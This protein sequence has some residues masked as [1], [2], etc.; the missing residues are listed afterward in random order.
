M[1]PLTIGKGVE[2]MLPKRR[3]IF[4]FAATAVFAPASVAMSLLEAPSLPL[5]ILTYVTYALAAVSFGLSIYL[6]VCFI[7]SFIPR[8]MELAHRTAF[9]GRIVDDY[10]FRTMF[11]GYGSLAINVF[12]A[13][14]KAAAGW[15]YS[16]VWLIALALYYLVLCVTK[17]LVLRRGRKRM[18]GETAPERLCREWKIY[19]MCGALLALMTVTLQGIIILIVEQGN[20]FTYQGTLIFAVALYDFYCLIS[21]IVYMARAR[22]KHSPLVVSVKAIS[23]ATSLIAMLTLQTAMFASFSDGLN[24]Q[25]QKLMNILTGTAVCVILIVWGVFMARRS[26]RELKKLREEER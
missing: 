19:R 17:A 10:T 3:V 14:T 9:T 23:F 16:S 18:P 8:L 20:T 25:W 24:A 13:L 12:F 11:T 6:I 26:G 5:R 4:I 7:K 2:K 15:Y 22:K 21:S 1:L